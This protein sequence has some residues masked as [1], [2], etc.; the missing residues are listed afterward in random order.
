MTPINIQ[1]LESGIARIVSLQDQIQ[2]NHAELKKE[3]KQLCLDLKKEISNRQLKPTIIDML[4]E[5][6]GKTSNAAQQYYRHILVT[7]RFWNF[8]FIKLVIRVITE[9]GSDS[10]EK[11]SSQGA[12]NKL[13]LAA[14]G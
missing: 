11:K 10:S 3:R 8:E 5:Q 6:E 9:S 12:T 1:D 4:V 2:K 7:H 13:R 14:T